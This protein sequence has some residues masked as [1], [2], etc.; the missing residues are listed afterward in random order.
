V[1]LPDLGVGMIYLPG[2]DPL[3][4]AAQDLLDVIEIEPQTS[5]YR[6]GSGY[7]RGEAFLGRVERMPQR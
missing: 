5:W 4:E 2:L 7:R 6:Q 3:V 1:D